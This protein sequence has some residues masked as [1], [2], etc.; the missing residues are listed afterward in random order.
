M[1]KERRVAP[2]RDYTV[3]VRFRIRRDVFA[4]APPRKPTARGERAVA[5][6]APDV[7]DGEMV[8]ISQLG[9]YFKSSGHVAFG[10]E[11]EMSF[12][13]AGE[14]TG[15]NPLDIRCNARV[16]HVNASIDGEGTSGI[17][18]AIGRFAT[19]SC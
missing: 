3:K 10:E 14:L 1:S 16:V 8:N 19:G 2:R 17:G 11:I 12:R 7:F 5:T 15:R 9:I 4:P 18:A 13:L 6:L